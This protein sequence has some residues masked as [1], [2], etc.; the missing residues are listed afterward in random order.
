[1]RYNFCIVA[2][3]FTLT[4]VTLLAYSSCSGSRS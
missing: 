2:S 1:M 3:Y 4:L